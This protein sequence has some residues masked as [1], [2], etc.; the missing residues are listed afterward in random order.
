MP[1][2][3]ELL[4]SDAFTAFQ[5]RALGLNC[6]RYKYEFALRIL[7]KSFPTSMVIL[8]EREF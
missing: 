2:D 1:Y 4:Y 5:M 3:S 8:S 7:Q 6:Y